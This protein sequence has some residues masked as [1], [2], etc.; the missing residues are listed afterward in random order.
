MDLCSVSALP[1]D[2]PR[3]KKTA[4]TYSVQGISTNSNFIFG[5]FGDG[6]EWHGMAFPCLLLTSHR[7]T[8]VKKS[9]MMIPKTYTNMIAIRIKKRNPTA[10]MKVFSR[11]FSKS[12]TP[13][14]HC[15][16]GS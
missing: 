13:M 7:I 15:V 14:Q 1:D 12:N 3:L 9:H 4:M 10:K 16:R 6:T 2:L 11:T 8:H 5:G